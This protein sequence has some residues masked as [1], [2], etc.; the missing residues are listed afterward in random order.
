MEAKHRLALPV[1]LLPALLLP[2]LSAARPARGADPQKLLITSKR[3]GNEDIYLVNADG[4]DAKNLTNNAAADNAPCWSPDGKRI[5]FA[6]DRAGK[7]DIWVMDAYGTNQKPLTTDPAEE[8][9]PQWSPDGK[10]IA[11]IRQIKESDWDV[12]VMD[13]DGGNQ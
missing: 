6:S 13:A 12:F 11:F 4:T 5:V 2:L 7:R 10:K 1:V 8:R 9:T 3:G